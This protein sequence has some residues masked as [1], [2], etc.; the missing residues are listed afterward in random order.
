MNIDEMKPGRELDALVAEKVMGYA[1]CPIH[2]GYSCCGRV[3]RR[4]STDIAGA[5]QVVEHLEINGQYDFKLESVVPNSDPPVYQAQFGE[6]RSSWE[7]E[8][9]HAICL[10]ALKAVDNQPDQPRC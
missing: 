8:A 5:W 7:F 6:H 3:W 10:A 9:P 1:F 4:C 2:H